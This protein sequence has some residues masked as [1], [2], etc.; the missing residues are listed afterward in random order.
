MTLLDSA[1]EL[2]LLVDSTK[3]GTEALYHLCPIESCDLIITDN[4]VDPDA[5][6]KVNK[7]TKV[8]IAE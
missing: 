4:N 2:I 1:A 3:I 7:M 6:R 5:L 8:I